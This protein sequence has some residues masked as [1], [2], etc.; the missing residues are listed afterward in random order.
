MSKII[1]NAY[2][3]LGDILGFKSNEIFT[4]AQ[5]V[6]EV[7]DFLAQRYNS[8]FKEYLIDQQS[9]LLRNSFRILIN[10]TDIEFRDKLKTSIFDGD[11]I[12]FFPPVG[13]G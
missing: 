11:E 3:I 12:T 2:A 1:I 13:G 8:S 7:V 6:E 9:N 4:S 5:T 10:G